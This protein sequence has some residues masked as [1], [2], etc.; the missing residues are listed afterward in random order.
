MIEIT[1]WVANLL[2]LGV[3]ALM[4]GVGLFMVMLVVFSVKDFI[5]MRWNK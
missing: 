3:G 4:F 1:N 2:L 5:Q